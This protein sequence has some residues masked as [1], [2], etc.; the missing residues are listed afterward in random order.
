MI[1]DGIIWMKDIIHKKLI[2][3]RRKKLYK[4]PSEMNNNN[5]NLQCSW[6]LEKSTHSYL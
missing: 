2:Y 4:I 3:F 5:N 6:C 1:L